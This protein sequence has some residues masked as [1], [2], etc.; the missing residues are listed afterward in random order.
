MLKS[1]FIKNAQA[2]LVLSMFILS[3]PARAS[4]NAGDFTGANAVVCFSSEQISASVKKKTADLHR[5]QNKSH[6]LENVSLKEIVKVELLDLLEAKGDFNDYEPI[7]FDEPL[8][9]GA[10]EKI[11]RRILEQ[12]KKKNSIATRIEKEF[13]ALKEIAVASPGGVKQANEMEHIM[14]PANCVIMRIGMQGNQWSN[15][16]DTYTRIFVYDSRLFSLMDPVSQA[17]FI[18]HET[19]RRFADWRL[20]VINIKRT[21]RYFFARGF[22][23]VDKVELADLIMTNL[24]SHWPATSTVFTPGGFLKGA[25]VETESD[26]VLFNLYE[27]MDYNQLGFNLPLAAGLV[28]YHSITRYLLGG[29][30]RKPIFIRSLLI[31]DQIEFYPGGQ[32]KL[33][34]LAEDSII[35]GQFRSAGSKIKFS[36]DG[37][38]LP[39]K[40]HK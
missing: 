15:D 10:Y 27:P 23:E 20:P 16:H 24:D 12:I 35:K 38:I 21:V 29:T 25:E 4:I 32:L 5:S 31:K 2:S 34:V 17:A 13:D 9:K 40:Y 8:K 7:R 39:N 3:A 37:G 22:D 19:L 6:P 33:V 28:T 26:T 30:L 14:V 11:F 36:K 1:F 18:M